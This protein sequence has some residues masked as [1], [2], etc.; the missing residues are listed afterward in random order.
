MKMMRLGHA[1]Y[2][3]TS[4]SGKKHLIDP[5]LSGNPGCP[6]AY[7][8]PEFL[9]TIDTVYLT[10]GHFDHTAGLKELVDANPD[11]LIVCQ[12]EMGLILLQSG[13]QNVHLLNYGGSVEFDD[14]KVSMVQALHTSSF[15]ETENTPLYAGQPAGYVYDFMNDVTLY[16]SGD[17]TMTMDMKLI[18]EVYQPDLAILSSSGQFVM[19]PREA[20]Y[21]TKNLLDVKYVIPNHHFPT[22]ETSPRP[23]VLENMLQN[24]PV[25]ETMMEKDQELF[26]LLR[27][28]K[29]TEVILLNFGE[30]REFSEQK[31][32][33]K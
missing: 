7:T 18:Q 17:T 27:D 29:K 23:E 9:K 21:V 19:G 15:K 12:Y 32:S 14:V 31:V 30:E 1:S 24:F 26:E 16:H 28:Y 11:V 4:R 20:A 10:H 6:E 3:L 13:Y 5:F 33:H 22:K 2:L 25:I 8:K